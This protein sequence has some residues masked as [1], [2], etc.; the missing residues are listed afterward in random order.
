MKTFLSALFLVSFH[1]V[2]SQKTIYQ[3]ETFETLSKNHKI[4]AIIPFRAVLELDEK[5]EDTNLDTLKIQEGLAVQSAFETY[6]LKRKKRKGFTVEFQDTKLTNALL[7]KNGI[8]ESTIDVYTI[9]ELSRIL[10][11]DG[12]VHG[13]LRINALI[14]KG[15]ST[16]YDF[17]SFITG[18]SDYGRIAVKVSDGQTDK[19]LWK[20]EKT[21]NRKSGRNTNAIVE[22]MMKQA[23]RKFPYDKD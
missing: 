20:Y 16:S 1:L 2:V 23:T 13:D 11:V 21:I 3:S 7:K 17:I 6:F 12:I 10:G 14:S 18:K 15:V 5:P 4:L 9:K 22:S 8:S 19:L